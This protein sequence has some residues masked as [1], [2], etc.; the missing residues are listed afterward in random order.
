MQF[1]MDNLADLTDE[2][3]SRRAEIMATWPADD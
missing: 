2:W 1:H 3:H